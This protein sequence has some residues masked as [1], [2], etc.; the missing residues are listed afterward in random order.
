[1]PLINIADIELFYSITCPV[2]LTGHLEDRILPGLAFEYARL[3][4]LIPNCSIFLSAKANHPYL[5]RPFMW[6]DPDGFKRVVYPFLENIPA[7]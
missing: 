2:L 6:T 7:Q 1:M 5:E 4:H 3:S